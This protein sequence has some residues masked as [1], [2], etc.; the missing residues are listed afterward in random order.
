M[1]GLAKP[2]L[3]RFVVD[4]CRRALVHWGMWFGQ[5]EQQLGHRKAVELE[6][7]AFDRWLPILMARLGKTLGFEVRDGLPAKLLDLDSEKLVE[8]A[9]ALSVNWLA[10]DGVWF[11]AVEAELGMQAAKLCNDCC[12][13]HFSP[14]E[15]WRIKSLLGLPERAGLDGLE[16]ALGF[17]LYGMINR[18]SIR[19]EK[20][21]S[22][23]FEMN[24]CR[25]QTARKRKG[26]ED[27]PCKSA[28]LIEYPFFARAID[29]RI[30]TECIGCP[31]DDHP[32]EWW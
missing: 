22:I 15:A 13:A 32:A 24:E 1:E 19:R 28:G 14:F 18:Q 31:P 26:L 16:R 10:G 20:D 21:G 5:V 6:Q 25:V 27:Y 12:W 8:L 3:V 2:Q 9:R 30:R 11:Q 23:R 7:A 4:L 17:R 29:P